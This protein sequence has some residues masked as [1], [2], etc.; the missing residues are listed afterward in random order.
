MIGKCIA[1]QAQATFFSISASSLTSKWVGESEKLVRA[2]FTLARIK[3]PSVI[4]IDEIDSILTQ[5]SDG[6]FEATRRL[7][8]EFLVQFDGA[9]VASDDRILVI[10]A[11]NR[12]QELDEAARRRLVKRLY[13]PLP[14]LAA[15]RTI[16]TNLLKNER[17]FL[18]AEGDLDY[19]ANL[20]N[21]YSGSDMAN[22]CHEAS[23]G[24]LRKCG[25][26]ASIKAEDIPPICMEDFK[27]AMSQVRASV[28]ERDL[29]GYVEWNS[30]Y[31]TLDIPTK[32]SINQK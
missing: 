27:M 31:G 29:E 26:L 9:G 16:I 24:A 32:P 19:I 11:T 12:P 7:K 10:G 4:F 13:I 23:F 20:T 18:S 14:D 17:H 21:G 2:L 5:R 15:R 8:T 6:E 3:Q 1:S 25:D 30:K 28:S 22:L